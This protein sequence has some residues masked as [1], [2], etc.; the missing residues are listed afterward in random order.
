[1]AYNG[2]PDRPSPKPPSHG[3][4]QRFPNTVMHKFTFYIGDAQS[5]L[6]RRTTAGI[7]YVF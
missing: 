5:F 3:F 2:H 7:L 4:I 6:A 1:M